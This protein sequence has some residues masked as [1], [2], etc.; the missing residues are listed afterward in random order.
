MSEEAELVFV[1]L[2]SLLETVL[3][4]QTTLQRQLQRGAHLLTRERT[5]GKS[6]VDLSLVDVQRIAVGQQLLASRSDEDKTEPL[7]SLRVPSDDDDADDDDGDDDDDD[8]CATVPALIAFGG[9][10]PS[11]VLREAQTTYVDAL[12]EVVALAN[13]TTRLKALLREYALKKND[14]KRVDQSQPLS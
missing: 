14:E 13:D 5:H 9:A 10:L 12:R 1:E 11:H 4:R 7:F 3:D 2:L 6:R 8:Q